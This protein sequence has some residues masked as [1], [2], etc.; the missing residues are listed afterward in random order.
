MAVPEVTAAEALIACFVFLGFLSFS[1]LHKY[2]GL[3]IWLQTFL[4]TFL[5]SLNL[6]YIEEN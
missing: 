2:L 3:G 6:H 1:F 4:M 5:T